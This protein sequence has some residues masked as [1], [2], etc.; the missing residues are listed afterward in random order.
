MSAPRVLF[1]PSGAARMHRSILLV[2]LVL[3]AAPA[4]QAQLPLAPPPRLAPP[5]LLYVKLAGPKGMKATFYHSAGPGQTFD[6]PLII[7]LRPGYRYRL[8]L[9][10]LAD[11]P[12]E[13]F[14]PTLEARGSL[15]L[16]DSLSHADFPAPLVFSNEDFA[17]A[18]DN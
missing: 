9:S 3:L 1:R 7:G 17:R 12:G 15:I 8:A 14:Y 5:P 2:A 16:S 10:N 6:A 4:A 13:T 11:F 18:A